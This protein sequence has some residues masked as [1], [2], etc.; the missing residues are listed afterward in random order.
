MRMYIFQFSNLLLEKLGISRNR[1]QAVLQ[2]ADANKSGKIEYKR[3]LETV[4]SYRLNTEQASKLKQIGT[5][6]AYAEEF[7]CSPPKLFIAL[8]KNNDLIFD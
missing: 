6:L 8:S 3:F 2:R 1:L 5:A 4:Q 7:S